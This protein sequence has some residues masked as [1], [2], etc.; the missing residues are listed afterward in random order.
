[1]SDY[2]SRNSRY[3]V[4]TIEDQPVVEDVV[5]SRDEDSYL[6]PKSWK[7]GELT[8]SLQKKMTLPPVSMETKQPVALP[9][10]LQDA[11]QEKKAETEL[12]NFSSMA[13][14]VRDR[15]TNSQ[16]VSMSVPALV[17]VVLLLSVLSFFAGR[18]SADT[19]KQI[20]AQENP[21]P[22]IIPIATPLPAALGTP[23]EIIKAARDEFS[24]IGRAHV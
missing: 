3:I 20:Q 24:E 19:S 13:T 1:M 23:D 12:L 18:F 11:P 10:F 14:V 15:L 6:P 7:P 22:T 17:T 9:Q 4:Q 5:V 8:L 2:S 21:L 16:L